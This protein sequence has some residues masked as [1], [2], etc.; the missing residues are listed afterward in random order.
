MIPAA[1]SAAPALD[2]RATIL[3]VDDDDAVRDVVSQVLSDEGYRVRQAS[4]GLA[5]LAALQTDPIHL[6]LAD[7]QMPRLGGLALAHLLLA[8]VHPVPVVLMGAVAPRARPA[9]APFVA[10]PFMLEQL[11]R[12]I[13]EALSRRASRQHVWHVSGEPTWRPG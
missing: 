3:V 9:E 2:A 1:V 11:L 7:V 10:K 13:A 4:D 5:A 12:V 6:V 8:R